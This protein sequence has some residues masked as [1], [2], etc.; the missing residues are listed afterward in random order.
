MLS[1][2]WVFAWD[3]FKG[4][5]ALLAPDKTI[6][7][8]FVVLFC[9][10]ERQKFLKA[11]Q[12]HQ[13]PCKLCVLLLGTPACP[14]PASFF[15]KEVCFSAHCS[16]HASCL[17]SLFCKHLLGD[18]T[19]RLYI[20]TAPLGRFTVSRHL[21]LQTSALSS[22]KTEIIMVLSSSQIVGKIGLDDTCKIEKK[23]TT[24][25]TRVLHKC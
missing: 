6:L 19:S 15:E 13:F 24:P 10:R 9:I 3:G 2:I 17:P 21:T 16:F 4:S 22:G 12:Y 20:L 18:I 11:R 5:C 25:D 23:S 14:G 8:P 7:T 1:N